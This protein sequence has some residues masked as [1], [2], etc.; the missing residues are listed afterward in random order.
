MFSKEFYNYLINKNKQTIFFIF[1]IMFFFGPCFTILNILDQDKSYLGDL[2]D[3]IVLLTAFHG[4]IAFT[5]PFINFSFKSNKRALDIFN[6]LPV[7]KDKQVN[8]LLIFQWLEVCVVYLVNFLLI[9]II[10]FFRGICL[11]S[12]ANVLLLLTIFFGTAVLMTVNSAI[13]LKTNHLV[14]AVIITGAYSFL[15]IALY[16]LFN[17]IVYAHAYGVNY[18]IDFAS[19][20]YLSPV[21][22]WVE[23]FAT[24]LDK[25]TGIGY[26]IAAEGTFSFSLVWMIVLL[27]ASYLIVRH[28][29]INAKAEKAGDLSDNF[30]AYPLVSYLYQFVVIMMIASA[31]REIGFV[32]QCVLYLAALIVLIIIDCVYKRRIKIDPKKVGIF[33]LTVLLCLGINKIADITHGFG[34]SKLFPKN[35][36]DVRVSYY[37]S[38][39]CTKKGTEEVYTYNIERQYELTNKEDI[40]TL[41]SMQS[42]AVDEHFRLDVE[43]SDYEHSSDYDIDDPVPFE[44]NNNVSIYYSLKKSET[45]LVNLASYYYHMTTRSFI[46]GLESFDDNQF[47]CNIYVYSTSDEYYENFDFDNIEDFLA[48]FEFIR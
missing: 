10:F 45:N 25:F 13:I 27:V 5:M 7:N 40:E 30:F 31:S 17:V 12:Q 28:D 15:P 1:L 24:V 36:T 39:F 20:F 33:A 6:S 8:T 22:S 42:E 34:Y 26:W 11:G 4:I 46:R 29:Y 37:S 21:A 32:L 35:A 14:D 19:I 47:Y 3:N 2:V 41:K 44:D 16:A 9:T 18:Y 48:E 43:G 38:G 23:I